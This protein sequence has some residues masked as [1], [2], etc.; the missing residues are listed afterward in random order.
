VTVEVSDLGCGM[1]P[2]VQ[3][4]IFD[5]FFTTKFTGRG[6]GMAAVL[7]IVRGHRGAIRID[8]EPGR[9]TTIG[10]LFPASDRQ[11][12]PGP[13]GPGPGSPWQGRGT[14]LLADDD[15]AVREVSADMLRMMGFDVLVA[16]D[17]GSAL[18]LFRAHR[19]AIRCVV[20]DM[21]MPQVGGVEALSELRRLDPGVRVVLASGYGEQDVVDRLPAGGVVRLLEKPF[22]FE[23]LRAGLRE[24]LR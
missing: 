19:A 8:S 20:L 2:E 10:I 13:A 1:T 16:E 9:G 23:T 18:E 3:A 24:A 12:A 22:D 15:A 5:P 14:V 17:G 6:L 21:A 7:G 4:R 11:L